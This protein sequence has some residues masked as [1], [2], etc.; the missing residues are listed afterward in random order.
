MDTLR[1]EYTLANIAL[2]RRRIEI[3]PFRRFVHT[4]AGRCAHRHASQVPPRTLSK[5]TQIRIEPVS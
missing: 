2:A 4:R 5:S 1:R 3:E